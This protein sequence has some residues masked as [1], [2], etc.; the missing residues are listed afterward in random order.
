MPRT[1][2]DIDVLQEYINGVMERAAHHAGRVEEIALAVAG[3]IVWRKSG[4]VRVY[5]REGKMTNALWVEIGNQQ[6]ALS[7]SHD[8]EQIEVRFGNMR[9]E[10]VAS[11]DNSSTKHL[12]KLRRFK[13]NSMKLLEKLPGLS[14]QLSISERFASDSKLN[15]PRPSNNSTNLNSI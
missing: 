14:R 6:Y 4:P 9:G 10:V 15:T 5:E 13:Q 11:F 3:A 2:T 8:A 1:V 12:I 7:Y